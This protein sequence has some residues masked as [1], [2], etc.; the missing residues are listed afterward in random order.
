MSDQALSSLELLALAGL[1]EGPG[2]GYLIAK[3]IEALSERTVRVRPGNLYRVLDRLEARGLVES[4]TS[5][6]DEASVDDRRQY[7]QA[8]QEGRRVAAG[9]LA[10]YAQVLHGSPRLR[11]AAGT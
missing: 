6:G 2:Y 8:T 1:S 9:Q 4:A 7:Y 3:R 11:D 10:M 5:P